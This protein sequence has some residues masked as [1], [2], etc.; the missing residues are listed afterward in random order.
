ML[1]FAEAKEKVELGTTASLLLGNGFSRAWNNAIFSYDNLLDSADF[2][3]RSGQIRSLFDKLGTADFEKA[4]RA[5]VAARTVLEC[6]GDQEVLIA[7]IKQDEELL[8]NAL[9]TVL[10]RTHPARPRDVTDDQYIA[11]R[12]FLAEFEAVFTVNYDLLVNLQ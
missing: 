11:A 10:A 2:G 6:Y 8:K 7:Q 3:V 1:T 9:V 5:L 4:M 12:T